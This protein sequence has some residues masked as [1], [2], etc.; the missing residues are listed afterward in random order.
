[1][2]KPIRN[3]NARFLTPEM[4]TKRYNLCRESIVK[5]SRESGSLIKFGRSVRIDTEKLDKLKSAKEH[6]GEIKKQT[7]LFDES[8]EF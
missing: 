8:E 2:K 7:S 1:M 3:D 5:L 6:L 4:A